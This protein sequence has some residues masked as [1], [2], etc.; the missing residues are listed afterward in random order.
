MHHHRLSFLFVFLAWAALATSFLNNDFSVANVAQHSN[1]RLPAH[2]RFAASWGSHEGSMLLWAL[3][4]GGWTFAVSLRSRHLPDEMVA[5]VIGV[6][7][8]V[9]FGFLLFLLLT[10]NPF[11]RLFPPAQDGRDPTKAKEAAVAAFIAFVEGHARRRPVVLLL[12]DIHWADDDLLALVG[13]PLVA[14]ARFPV[15]IL[16]T[17]R[18]ALRD[19]WAPPR[20]STAGG[21][22]VCV[23]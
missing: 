10:S 15:V 18:Q 22:P 2:Y 21:R 9:S 17:A 19:R 20:P 5:R 16:A 1:L 14:L 11:D 13:S 23:P 3:M 4:L 8:L 7:G 6:M 12:S